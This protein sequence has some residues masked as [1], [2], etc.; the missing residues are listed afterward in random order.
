MTYGDKIRGFNNHQLAT[1]LAK[2]DI[3]N[4]ER[5]I[6]NLNDV[7]RGDGLKPCSFED[8]YRLHLEAL[9]K[10]FGN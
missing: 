1:M 8:R 4:D 5:F 10:D 6:E 9:I 3:A 7:G 2:I